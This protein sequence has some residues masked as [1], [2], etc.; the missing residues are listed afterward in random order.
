MTFSGQYITIGLANMLNSQPS[1][2]LQ[3]PLQQHKMVER[4]IYKWKTTNDN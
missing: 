1:I 2:T 3:W 4:Q